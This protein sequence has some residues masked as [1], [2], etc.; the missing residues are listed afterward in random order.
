VAIAERVLQQRVSCEPHLESLDIDQRSRGAIFLNA[1][2][3]APR[4][5][6]FPVL[7]VVD[8]AQ[9]FAPPRLG[10]VDE[11]ARRVAL[12]A[13]TNLMCR[14]RKRGL[15]GITGDSGPR[16]ARQNVAAEK[17]GGGGANP[18]GPPFPRHRLARAAGRSA[19]PR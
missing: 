17:G 11:A 19:R 7:V 8:D 16:Q 10:D 14:G 2:F 6:W 1:R 5:F 18:D 3:D 12:A 9:I 15:S 4:E 13:M